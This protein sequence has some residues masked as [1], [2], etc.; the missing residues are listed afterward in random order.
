VDYDKLTSDRLGERSEAVRAQVEAARAIQRACFDDPSIG[1]TLTCN[2]DM[3]P[4]EVRRYCEVDVA[5]KALLPRAA[6]ARGDAGPTHA[7][8]RT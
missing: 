5:G 4:A 6:S 3:G 8:A 2:A 1:R 7:W